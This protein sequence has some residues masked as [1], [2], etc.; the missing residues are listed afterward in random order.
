M[1]ATTPAGQNISASSLS[2]AD[3]GLSTST[4]PL[5]RTTASQSSQYCHRLAEIVSRA[6]VKNSLDILFQQEK[7]GTTTPVTSELLYHAGKI[8]VD[9]KVAAGAFVVEAADFAAVACWE[10]PSATPPPFTE[11][12]LDEMAVKKP[13]LAQFQRDVHAARM[14]CLGEGQRYWNLSLMARDPNR[15]DKGAVR[16]V[17]ERY[18]ARA[19]AEGLPVWLVAAN[20]RARDVYGYFGFRVVE[21]IHL[22][23]KDRREGDGQE[24]VLTWCMVCNWPPS[25]S[26][27]G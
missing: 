9:T 19:R 6:A 18:V 14:A 25:P 17:I 15:K 5:P 16:A 8:R 20:P 2:I 22:Y 21:T 1:D 23:A 27:R 12:Q 4:T 7:T 13:V 26:G 11:S 3:G 24:G 10:P